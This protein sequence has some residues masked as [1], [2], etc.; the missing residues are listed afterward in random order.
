MSI[1]SDNHQNNHRSKET[2]CSK[3][4]SIILITSVSIFVY[5]RPVQEPFCYMRFHCSSFHVI[6]SILISIILSDSRLEL[7]RVISSLASLAS[8]FNLVVSFSCHPHFKNG[9]ISGCINLNNSTS[10]W[11]R[12]SSSCQVNS[13]PHSRSTQSSGPQQQRSGSDHRPCSQLS[14]CDSKGS[15]ASAHHRSAQGHHRVLKE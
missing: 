3:K 4:E 5:L 12:G 13:E 11:S 1:R 8:A 15:R 2:T 7:N 14:G 6:Q 10:G 9:N